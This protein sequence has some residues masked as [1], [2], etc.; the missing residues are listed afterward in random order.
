MIKKL[1]LLFFLFSYSIFFA[2][3]ICNNGID[4]DGNGFIDC[5]DSQCSG[6]TDCNTFFYGKPAVNCN[7][8]PTNPAF[9]LNTI[10]QSPVNVSTRSTM[11]V[12]DVDNDGLPEVVCHQN[13][14]NELYILDGVTGALEVTIN[15]PAIADHVDAITI[16]DTDNDGFGE[17]YVVT[18]DNVLRCFEH[19]GTPKVGYTAPT[20]G[21]SNESIPGLA[22]FN[23]DGIPEVYKDNRIYNSLTG[24]L[25]ASGGS[26][27][28]GN[29]PGSNG[30]PAGM[31]V[32]AN[33]LPDNY[34]ATCDGLELVC[35]NEVY[36]VDIS[37]G[38]LI[39][40]P[41]SLPGA[42]NDGFASVA[43]LDL[44]GQ[45]DVVVVSSGK[46]YT[47]DPRTG[48]QLGNTFSIP[49]T[50]A[51]GRANIADYD[52]DGLPEIGAG[53]ND[54]YVVVDIDTAT[55]A[56]SQKWI[57]T[58]V[59]GS[60]HTTGSV[61]DF[62][63]D[64]KAQ[65]VYRDENILYVWDGETG[66]VLASVPCGSATRSELPTIVDVDGDGQVNIVCACGSSNGAAAGVVKAFN[67]STNQW[68]GSRKVMNQHSYFVTNINDDLSI[69]VQQQNNSLIPQINGFSSQSPIYDVNWVSNCIPLANVNITIDSAIY[70]AKPDSVIIVLTV[71]NTGSKVTTSPLTLS[72]YNGDPNSG[73]T[74][75]STIQRNKVIYVDSCLKDT[76][77]VHYNGSLL[78]YHIYVND[79]GSNPANA[80]QLLFMEC[81]STNNND[82]ILL[83]QPTL[84]VGITGDTI[85]CIYQSTAITASGA[86]T[87]SWSPSTGLNTSS[88]TNVTAN[89][90][91]TTTY[92]VTGTNT[93]TGCSSTKQFTIAV[94]PKPIAIFGSSGV[95]AGLTTQ[96]TDTSTTSTGS[97]TTWNYNF[98]DNNTLNILQNPT[99]VYDS[100]GTY[101]ATLIVANNFGCLDTVTK[102]VSVFYKPNSDFTSS[103]V[104][105]GDSIHLNNASTIHTSSSITSNVWSF[106]DNS[107]PISSINTAHLYATAGNF[108][109]KLVVTSANACKD[110][111]IVSINVFEPPTSAFS[112]N[113]ACFLDS[114]YFT[115]LSLNPS[116]GTISNWV[117]DFG[118]GSPSNSSNLNPNHIYTAVGTYFVSLINFS[119]NLGC[120]DTLIDTITVYPKP[121]ANWGVTE[122]CLNTASVFT[123]SSS[124]T[125]GVIA[126]WLWNFGDSSPV[127]NSQNTTHNYLTHG[128]YNISLI[129]TSTDGCKDSLV[130]N[131]LVHPL[132]TALFETTNICVDST[133]LFYNTSTIPTNNLNDVITSWNWN[134]GDGGTYSGNVN[135]SHQYLT[136]GNFPVQLLIETTFG[137][138]D[139]L[140]TT[141]TIHPNPVAQ[142]TVSDTAGCEEF[143]ITFENTSTIASPG[144]INSWVWSFGEGSTNNT[145]QQTN[146]CYTNSTEMPQTFTPSLM[147]SS[148]NGCTHTLTKNDFITVF[149]LPNVDFSVSP[150]VAQYTNPIIN[151]TNESSIA[152][153][154][155]WRF[156]DGDTSNV[157]NPDLHIYSDTG[158]YTIT[159]V[160]STVY[161]CVDTSAETIVIEPNF[162]FF[163]PNA[164]TPNEDGVNDFFIGKG[165]FITEFEM[166]IFD[167]WGNLVYETTDL[168]KPWN[169]KVKNG[170][171]FAQQDVYVY[172]IKVKDF[173]N[174]QHKFKGTVTLVK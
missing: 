5:Y 137:C 62:D 142:F 129:V 157:Q 135:V 29:N 75:V 119:S 2:Q 50:S 44:D 23:Q 164:F 149:P 100:G 15:C 16:G 68:V 22:D 89:P 54:R 92:T 110:S 168:N 138:K 111:S 52:N 60:Q 69:P 148:E 166:L 55:N 59:D 152:N 98:G 53:G 20:T 66:N 156:G 131:A 1:L 78:T 161:N 127:S 160:G 73:G 4:D 31:P 21:G 122:V 154:W 136:D 12:G 86:S 67:S 128:S 159:L 41:N 51:G 58:I 108:N 49:N 34:C 103:D 79:D 169:G 124:I 99:H 130:K 143:C 36:S 134:F 37:G 121:I 93:S 10:W 9:S 104:C 84:S 81:D 173:K 151:I 96:F 77:T 113:N 158:T 101:N 32:A 7:A 64:G 27:S 47:W 80:P 24:A 61:F 133:A 141:I 38:N 33:V 76:I 90:S 165:I 95:C 42:L 155:S 25:I 8:T 72:V 14:V 120:S 56:L 83:N 114:T 35:G 3:E 39:S 85:I 170:A 172:A 145:A 13:G 126:N 82:S 87:Y 28:T 94:N 70:C 91:A 45:L 102:T 48:L 107:T 26:G 97:I 57:K 144:V 40:I 105:L 140:T 153:V 11:M 112:Y 109:I 118:D 125:N 115:N 123:D 43:D 17:I 6:N 147:V 139:S 174:E 171:E 71:C 19:D 146:H 46:I 18:S 106:G 88:G 167:R 132:P 30:S 117:W 162:L 163:V 150:Q 74:I 65:V 116:S 63:C